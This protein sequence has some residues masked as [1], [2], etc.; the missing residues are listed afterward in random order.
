LKQ[1]EWRQIDWGGIWHGKWGEQLGGVCEWPP[2]TLI[3]S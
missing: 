2:F 1:R 3:T